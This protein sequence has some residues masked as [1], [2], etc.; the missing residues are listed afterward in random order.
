L[1]DADGLPL[2]SMGLEYQHFDDGGLFPASHSNPTPN[3]NRAI[4][5]IRLLK[6]ALDYIESEGSKLN[7]TPIRTMPIYF[8]RKAGKNPA[9]IS[10]DGDF[11][12][13]SI[14]IHL[15]QQDS[16]KTFVFPFEGKAA[17][18]YVL[19]RKGNMIIYIHERNT[20]PD[21]NDTAIAK[22]GSN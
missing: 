5:N 22:I 7:S 18:C 2:S 6:S 19:E 8:H 20:M 1:R 21:G 4:G 17:A 15:L 13:A 14:G 16:T 10:F 12:P 11:L 3:L 9:Y